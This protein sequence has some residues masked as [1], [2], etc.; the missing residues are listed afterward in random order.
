MEVMSVKTVGIQVLGLIATSIIA[1]LAGTSTALAA[2]SWHGVVGPGG[3][4]VRSAPTTAAAIVSSLA[5]GQPVTVV[6]WVT[7]QMVEGVNETWA[8]I[9]P[10]QY[11]YSAGLRK[12][13][14]AAPPPPPRTFPGRWIDVNLSEQIITAYNGAT[15]QFWA[16]MSSGAPGWETEVGVH[17]I[18]RRVPNET[19]SSAT[20]RVAVE[21]PYNLPN[22][23]YTQYFTSYGE[24]IHDNY[25]K[26][27]DSPFGIPTSHGCVGL[28]EAD[29]LR[30]WNFASVGTIVNIHE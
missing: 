21:I 5:P 13:L 8:E 22:V 4:N 1:V 7:G 27:P 17:R 29:A 28:P 30:F 24:A 15:P 12:P 9:G 25:W 19:M 23:L 14:P 16:V 10:G 26:G 20:L 18:L 11:V 2:G 3:A 6:G